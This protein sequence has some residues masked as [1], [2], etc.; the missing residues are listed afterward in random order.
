MSQVENFRGEQLKNFLHM[1][2]YLDDSHNTN[3]VAA[4]SI[5]DKI[6]LVKCRPCYVM[7]GLIIL[8]MVNIEKYPPMTTHS[9]NWVARFDIWMKTSE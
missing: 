2:K 4:W 7:G 6:L 1:K 3:E 8:F 5:H 9:F